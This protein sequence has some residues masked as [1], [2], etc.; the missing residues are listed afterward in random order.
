MVKSENKILKDRPG[1]D[2]RYAI[3]SDKIKSKLNWKPKINLNQG[4]I[5]TVEWYLENQNYFSQI[6]KKLFQK[7]LVIND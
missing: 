4:L 6:S 7:G 2:F 1:H 3:N 5:L